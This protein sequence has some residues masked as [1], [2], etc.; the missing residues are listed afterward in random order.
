MLRKAMVCRPLL[1]LVASCLALGDEDADRARWPLIYAAGEGDAATVISLLAQGRPTTE[2]SKDGESALHVAAIRGDSEV[3][4]ALIG[5]GA[6]VDART[7]EGPLIAM[8]PLH[9]AIYHGHTEMVRLLLEAGADPHLADQNGKTPLEMSAEAAQEG[10]ARMLREA[11]QARAGGET[12]GA[13][14]ADKD[15]I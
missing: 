6:E 10:S 7:P 3:V 12:G 14:D 4:R 15:E 9:W 5:A 11:I 1:L 8:T 13:A 2:R